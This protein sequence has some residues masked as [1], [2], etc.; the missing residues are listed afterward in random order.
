M[1]LRFGQQRH[2]RHEG[3]GLAE[4]PEPEAAF[5]MLALKRPVGQFLGQG[6]TGFRRQLLD[7]Q[8]SSG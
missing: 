8:A 3:E 1:I 2:A 5:Q 7:H 6:G 4:I